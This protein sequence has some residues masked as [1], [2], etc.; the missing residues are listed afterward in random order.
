MADFPNDFQT[1]L[2]IN[3]QPLG[4]FGGNPGKDREYH[5][6]FIKKSGK[7]P[8]ILVHG[9]T[10]TATHTQ[11]G[12]LKVI[13][14]L[15]RNEF[16]YTDE[17]FWALSYLGSGDNVIKDAYTSNVEDL[18]R[19]AD[20][21]R[22]YLEV[23][24]VDMVGH[25]LGC[26][27]IVCYLA[28]LKG[29][30]DPILWDQGE[31]YANAG[32]IVLLDGAMKGLSQFSLPLYP[33]DKYD[34]WLNDHPIYDCLSPDNTPYGMG[35]DMTVA[36]PAPHHVTYWCCMV[37]GGFVDQMDNFNR[38]TGHL[39]G[40]DQN[41]NYNV[42]SGIASHEKVKDEPAIIRDWAVYLNSVPPV[43]P[44]TITID[45]PSGNYGTDLSI[46]AS[47]DPVSAGPVRFVGKRIKQT[48]IAG[49]LETDIIE[50]KE[51]SLSGGET[52]TLTT[53][54][55][56]TVTFQADGA[57]NVFRTYGVGVQSPH[58][59]IITDNSVPFNP[60]LNVQATTDIGVIYMNNGGSDE[61]GWTATSAVSISDNTIVKAIAITNDG[62]AS[63]IVSKKFERPP[64]EQAHGTATEHYIAG[65]LD[66]NGYLH[67]GSKYGFMQA[68]TLYKIDGNWTDQENSQP[69]DT[70]IP[71]V[72]CSYESG[73]YHEPI[74]VCLTATDNEDP[75]PTLFYSTDGSTPTS[76][77]PSFVNR[78]F[79][80]FN[81]PGLKTLKYFARDRSGNS[82]G[83]ETKTFGMEIVHTQ[84][85]ISA[86]VA[87]VYHNEAI[88]VNI[89]ATDS[90]DPDV[91]VYY[92]E[93]GT[94]PDM[95]SSSFTNTKCF[96]LSE[97]RNHAIS[98]YAKDSSGNENRSIFHYV[99][100]DEVAPETRIFPSGGD[101]SGEIEVSMTT[102]EPVK[103][104]KYTTDGSTPDEENGIIYEGAF[105]LSDTTT[106]QF[107]SK[108]TQR[109]LENVKS[110]SFVLKTGPQKM[111][112]ENI[113]DIDGYIKA[114]TDGAHRS[115]VD[116][117]QLAVG[118]GWDRRISRAIVSFDTS[119][120][121]QAATI[122]RA[123]IQVK[124][125]SGFGDPWAN[126][127]LKIDI[128]NGK[129]GSDVLCQ[130]EDWDESPTAEGIAHIASF[131]SG[132][133]ESTDF[134]EAGRN[135]INK[136]GRTQMRLYF[137]PHEDM[138][139]LNYVFIEKGKD[140]R[141]FV[142]FT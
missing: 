55:I 9:N 49:H 121:P 128:K 114:T 123:Y 140:V 43:A 91:T 83:V 130:T 125:H 92:T 35:D 34:E 95:H 10:G 5:I 135:A 41:R 17:H 74:R 28:G 3:G 106:V 22:E 64:I 48:I 136:E 20:Y 59:E 94:V 73:T 141:L 87:E 38:M 68:F 33:K 84:P 80:D 137:D 100:Q 129:F 117:A 24:C 52:F 99:I 71:V 57:S 30:S 102:N 139:M 53:P 42:G 60:P 6:D 2:D 77:S 116:D 118:S 109:N 131:S 132:S 66:V 142:E 88:T 4:G 119:A 19:F 133:K 107:R 54:G 26:F 98:C 72:A 134:N 44:V 76:G 111:I 13:N 138:G 126:A 31:R 90:I 127:S 101:F 32:T 112:F 36:P 45:Q 113:P 58:V 105:V 7:A 40:A 39:D 89:S 104:I 82:T 81:T 37:P 93:D 51:G 11:W 23:D 120:I 21:V 18:R 16:G 110:V 85:F 78:G 65:R 61:Y 25:S 67:Y 46:S 79:L 63:E 15:K 69:V 1:I 12:W 70:T 124:Y 27:L 75:A 97:N 108:D 122:S 96:F 103:W 86:D 62:I 47:V 8:V 56:W 50:T 14:E 115:V 29:Q